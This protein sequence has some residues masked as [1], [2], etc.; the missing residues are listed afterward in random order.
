MRIPGADFAEVFNDSPIACLLVRADPPDW[1]ILAANAEYRRL[2]HKR[3]EELVGIPTFV[4]FPESHGTQTEGGERNV[5]ASFEAALADGETHVLP[6]Q[7]YD[8][9]SLTDPNEFEEHY[10]RLSSRVIAHGDGARPAVL[11]VVENA[12]EQVR[13]RTA[14]NVAEE[15][16]QSV[17]AQAPVAIA[18][19]IGSDHRFVIANPQYSALVGS[20]PLLGLPAREAL[21]ELA[22]Q[23]IFETM[24]R[25]FATGVPFVA[26]EQTVRLD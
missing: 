21:P 6:I 7:R 2:T 1:T 17:F 20:R 12:T 3:S 8:I 18:L 19:T 11:H 10:W 25:V 13:A 24:D 4:A 16:L 26:A 14:A 22:G 9:P 5:R 23:R 15:Q